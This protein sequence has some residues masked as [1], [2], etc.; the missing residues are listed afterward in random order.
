MLY[1]I[2]LSVSLL[3]S[4]AIQEA[5]PRSVEAI[6]VSTTEVRVYWLPAEGATGYRVRR[7]GQ[8]IATLP[9]TAQEF[10]DTGLPPDSTHR[11][12]VTA[13]Q[14]E[15][16]SPVR[17]Y[18]ERTFAP[19]PAE[20]RSTPQSQEGKQEKLPAVTYDVVI[21]QASSSGVA[22]AYEAARRGLR[23]ALIEPT[24]R[25]GGM[26]A[27]G[28]S[29]TDIRRPEHAS[30]FF[31]RFQNRVR[32]LYAREGVK[33]NGLQYE[34]RIA[35]QAMKSLLYEVPNLT[36]F[37]HAR[38]V[39]VLTR[40][41]PNEA[42]TSETP[43]FSPPYDPLS[44]GPMVPFPSP[45]S[46]SR[47]RV[48]AIEVEELG[49]D[50]QP[51]ERRA[52]F[53]A[54]MF[55][56][57]TDCGDLAAWAGAPFRVGR[58]PRTHAE[59]HAGVIYYDRAADKLLP[60]STG[61][62][63]K[64]LMSYAYLLTVKDYG[65]GAD[66]TIPRPPGYRKED[67]EHTPAWKE[68]WA[69]TSGRMPGGKYELNQ[70]PQ[71]NDLQVINYGYPTG[72]YAERARVEALYRNHV[73][74]YLYYIQTEQGQKQIGL[75]DDE[76]RD[77]GGFPPL[78]YVRE[79]RRILGEQ[80]PLEN[81]VTDARQIVRPESIG[82]GDYPMDSHAVRPKIDW[83]RPDMG[84][85]EYWLYRYTPWHE[86]PLGILIPRNLDNVF[87]TTAVSSTHVSFG[88][89]RLE[90]VRMAFGETAGAA[91]A[92][93]IRYHL[94]AREVPARQIQEDLLP[95]AANPL[96]DSR[97]YLS[98]LADAPPG[99]RHYRAIQ[100]L[101]ARGFS[102]TAEDLKPDAP[103]QRGELA[104][105]L[106]QLAARSAPPPQVLA[107]Y[108][109]NGAVETVERQAYFPYMGAPADRSAGPALQREPNQ[110]AILTRAEIA[111]W[112]LRALPPWKPSPSSG[113]DH[114]ADITDPNDKAAAE[115]L[116]AYGIDSRLWDGWNAYAPEGKL[117]F[118]PQAPLSHADLLA[119]LYL[120]Q[121]GLGPLFYDNPVDGRNGRP[122]PPPVFVTH[123]VAD[124]SQP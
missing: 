66:K 47:K 75:P 100:Y 72:D 77:S 61:Q 24:T 63:D 21:V 19:F 8:E 109:N 17:E 67:F 73:L 53:R 70:H 119:I 18:T 103:T 29:A 25:L 96:G 82:I 16:E 86:L 110:D 89:Y 111:R 11:Y 101:V 28:L 58:E 33:A 76:Y 50:G 71:G 27:N 13:L 30:G 81:D 68:S 62:G 88:T 56:D 105:W 22:A 4:K 52:L 12:E 37:R 120:A 74:G 116:Y 9:A 41:V 121:I 92:L 54:A 48:E 42:S 45:A 115:G 14:G 36:I 10:A 97:I 5:L 44:H 122:V 107:R 6:A 104:R 102:L 124:T 15:R 59:P 112:L 98:Y 46:P 95:H 49:A 108:Q 3:L 60:G 91:A 90:P 20:I 65:P 78:L 94:T 123:E 7:D 2:I 43:S 26:P 118:R 40:T 85:G 51:T 1:A 83:D 64:R 106:T 57:A 99:T 80:L 35:H 114:Y 39:R 23:T 79:G 38:I 117:F 55:I 34:P 69:V 31:V 113:Q 87:V 93:A 32:T 84:E